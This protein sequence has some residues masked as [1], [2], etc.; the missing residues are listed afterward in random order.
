MKKILL[1]FILALSF[2]ESNAIAGKKSHPSSFTKIPSNVATSS[3]Y[4]VSSFFTD[5]AKKSFDGNETNTKNAETQALEE[6]IAGLKLLKKSEQ[7]PEKAKEKFYNAA[8]LCDPRGMIEHAKLE[9][10]QGNLAESMRWATLAYQTYRILKTDIDT[11]PIADDFFDKALDVLKAEKET[12]FK[13]SSFKDI[14]NIKEQ[15]LL[16]IIDAKKDDVAAS[17]LKKKPLKYFNIDL[18]TFIKKNNEKTFY[19]PEL[20]KNKRIFLLKLYQKIN[21]LSIKQ[22]VYD[23]CKANE[24]QDDLANLCEEIALAAGKPAASGLIA[25]A[26]IYITNNNIKKAKNVLEKLEAPEIQIPA[27]FFELEAF[28]DI[29]RLLLEQIIS[30]QPNIDLELLK[31]VIYFLEKSK[32]TEAQYIIGVFYQE[33]FHEYKKAYECFLKS[34]DVFPSAKVSMAEIIR[35]GLHGENPDINKSLK[36]YLALETECTPNPPSKEHTDILPTVLNNIGSIYLCM[37]N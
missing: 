31:K 27:D 3:N 6:V 37:K 8:L 16:F 26:E 17:Y 19:D 29:G 25:L 13:K 30:E 24:D 35:N 15:I 10:A 12:K 4:T 23:F 9:Y 20:A 32:T 21:K 1:I 11:Y 36:I 18:N 14:K 7:E 28:L 5:F 22:T 2:S 33:C 34:A